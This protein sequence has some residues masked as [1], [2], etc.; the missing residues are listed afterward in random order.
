MWLLYT[1]TYGEGEGMGFLDGLWAL[2]GGGGAVVP[3]PAST[4]VAVPAPY[5]FDSLSNAL[6]GLG[7]ARD[8]G[9]AARP[10]VAQVPLSEGELRSLYRFNGLARR[11]VRLVPQEGTRRGWR[12]ADS[13]KAAAPMRPEDERL[14]VGAKVRTA[15]CKARHLGGALIVPVL[16]EVPAPDLAGDPQWRRKQALRPLDYSLVRSV[17]S[18][19]VVGRTEASASSWETD[20]S[21]PGYGRPRTWW[22]TPEIGGGSMELHASRVLYF[23]GSDLP[24]G[25]ASAGSGWDDSVLQACWDQVRD[26]TSIGQVAATV[27]QQ[28]TVQ[29]LRL[30][31]LDGRA[32]SDEQQSIAAQVSGFMRGLSV[33]NLAL[34]GA[35]NAGGVG[36]EFEI[37]HSPVSGF[38][39]L[40]A[41]AWEAL[42]AATGIPIPILAGQPPGGLNADGESHLTAWRGLVA[43]EQTAT[44]SEPL[45][46]LYRLLY[47]ASE[48]PTRGVEPERWSVEYLPLDEPTTKQTAEVAEVQARTDAI[49]LASGVLTREQVARGRFGGGDGGIDPLTD[50]ELVALRP[51]PVP[52]PAPVPTPAP[53]SNTPQPGPSNT[54]PA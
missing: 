20:V 6:S 25:L 17:R 34:L 36:D 10:D 3:A 32:T 40:D 48:G 24:D 35:K 9:R 50:V 43:D 46:A 12:V 52:S 39:D 41:A 30:A 47:R 44:L 19:L 27:A 22:I 11:I 8:K 4:S 7:S 2:F 15:W 28:L 26:K 13:T 53:P 14:G 42:S 18:L 51:T 37:L 31:S 38:A 45:T 54:P 33:G 29:V 21:S 1:T 5:R 23:R 49:Y 16:D